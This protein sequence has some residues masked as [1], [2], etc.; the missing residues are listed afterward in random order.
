MHLDIQIIPPEAN[1]VCFGWYEF[2]G[3]KIPS[4]F[5]CVW[6]GISSDKSAAGSVVNKLETFRTTNR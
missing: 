5:C 2:G 6:I 1:G 4:Q 3:K